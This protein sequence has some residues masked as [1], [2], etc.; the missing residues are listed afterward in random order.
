MYALSKAVD[1][2]PTLWVHN[3][4]GQPCRQH[5]DPTFPQPVDGMLLLNQSNPAM[6]KLFVETAKAAVA[7]KGHFRGIFVDS[8]QS[9]G[10]GDLGVDGRAKCAMSDAARRAL[11]TGNERLLVELQEAV[12]A[13]RLVI[14]KD[15]HG[16]YNSTAFCNTEFLSDA[17]C[18]SY[19]ADPRSP[20]LANTCD[21]Q[22]AAAIA[23]GKRGQ[24]VQAHGEF[25]RNALAGSA[26]AQFEFTLA[27]YLVVASETSYYG[28]SDGW[29][30]NGTRWHAEYDRPLGA[31]LADAERD[32][33]G[34]WT[35]R[36]KHAH[37]TLD[38][39]H[40]TSKIA[41]G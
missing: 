39:A 40:H 38:V 16:V 7:S 29:Y 26:Q 9:W 33:A 41:W 1:A 12:G 20:A 4:S 14:A 36:F 25:N 8:A 10:Q 22:M 21:V 31:P 6:R 5:G 34:V 24:L 3:A 35:R 2:D 28:F 15:G 27:A 23:A 18:S 32:A 17:F 13:D 30:Y 37:V 11:A 19:S